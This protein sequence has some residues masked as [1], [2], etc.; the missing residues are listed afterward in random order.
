MCGD[1]LVVVVVV[2]IVVLLLLRFP[3]LEAKEITFVNSPSS[4]FSVFVCSAGMHLFHYQH[5]FRGSRK[6]YV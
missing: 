1:T 4:M 5:I 6:K 3:G 2:A